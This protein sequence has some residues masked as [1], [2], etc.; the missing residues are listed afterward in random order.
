[1]PR[2]DIT[3]VNANFYHPK[4]KQ[5]QI[6]QGRPMTARGQHQNKVFIQWQATALRK[7]KNSE[8]KYLFKE[9]CFNL[10]VTKF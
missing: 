3:V 5:D 2:Q 9:N 4:T 1:M 6:P 7:K 8:F 10:E